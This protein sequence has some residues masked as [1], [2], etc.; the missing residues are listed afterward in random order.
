VLLAKEQG[1]HRIGQSDQQAEEQREKL[2][3]N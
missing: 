1:G 2:P 3:Y